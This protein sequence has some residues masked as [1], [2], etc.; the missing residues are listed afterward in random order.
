[1][2]QT[3]TILVVDDDP[4]Y[5]ALMQLVLSGQGYA[6]ETAR[7][8]A[9]AIELVSKKGADLILLDLMMPDV[10]GFQV[11]RHL[12]ASTDFCRIPVFVISALTDPETKR[13]VLSLGA[14]EFFDKAVD[15][16]E[17]KGRIVG[18]LKVP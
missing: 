11:L 16:E 14:D 9:E 15:L 8:G 10:D 1:M 18:R 17:L 3:A 4:S 7:G 5:N 6:V 2:D 12:K 13:N